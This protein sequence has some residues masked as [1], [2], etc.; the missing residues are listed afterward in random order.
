MNPTTVRLDEL[1]RQ[2]LAQLRQETGA[3]LTDLVR[4]Y[5]AAHIGGELDGVRG[6]PK[7]RKA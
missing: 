7:R 3:T 5:L 1:S 4:A 2:R 6:I